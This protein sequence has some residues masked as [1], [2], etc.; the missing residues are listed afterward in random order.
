MPRPKPKLP[1]GPG[2]PRKPPG[3]RHIPVSLKLHPE[4]WGLARSLADTAFGG[5]FSAAVSHGIRIA[6]AGLEPA[7]PPLK[8]RGR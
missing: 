1:A 5:D 3:E 2:R 4:V 8:E 6:S 7:E